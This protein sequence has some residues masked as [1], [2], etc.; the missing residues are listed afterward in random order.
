[1]S[2][3]IKIKNPQ[4]KDN[5]PVE[6]QRAED[7]YKRTNGAIDASVN[8]YGTTMKYSKKSLLDAFNQNN[9]QQGKDKDDRYSAKRDAIALKNGTIDYR[10]IIRYLNPTAWKNILGI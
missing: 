3:K 2:F 9:R 5:K 1:M 8:A 7:L 6:E 10:K 4:I